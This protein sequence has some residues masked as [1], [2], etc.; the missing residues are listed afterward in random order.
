LAAK[1]LILTPIDQEE[2]QSQ[3]GMSLFQVVSLEVLQDPIALLLELLSVL[4]EF[5]AIGLL[6]ISKAMLHTHRVN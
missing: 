5:L 2:Q 6:W 1:L 3:Q 4:F